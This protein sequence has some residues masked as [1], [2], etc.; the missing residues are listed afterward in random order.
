MLMVRMHAS[1]NEIK[2]LIHS[3]LTPNIV[4]QFAFFGMKS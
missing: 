4:I 3:T 1:F 2:K